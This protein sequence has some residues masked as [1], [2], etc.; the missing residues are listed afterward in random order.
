MFVSCCPSAPPGIKPPDTPLVKNVCD[1]AYLLCGVGRVLIENFGYFA[2]EPFQWV[3]V[4]RCDILIR[5]TIIAG[6][7]E[8]SILRRKGVWLDWRGGFRKRFHVCRCGNFR[9]GNVLL[10]HEFEKI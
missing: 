10:I 3:F 6:P 4:Q 1:T 8:V 2:V 5:A 9:V 7:V